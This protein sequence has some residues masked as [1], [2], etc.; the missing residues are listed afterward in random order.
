M[1]CYET[2]NI[3]SLFRHSDALALH[4][5]NHE[6]AE[7]KE[8]RY[9]EEL[10][11]TADNHILA[12]LICIAACKISLHHILIEAGRGNGHEHTR[13]ELFPEESRLFGIVEEKQSRRRMMSDRRCHIAEA[14]AEICC[15]EIDAQ[16]DRHYQTETF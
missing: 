10:G 12:R 7:K 3:V 1:E 11:D 6:C 9:D 14:E 5:D 15:H 4:E 2:E 16:N 13:K 8:K